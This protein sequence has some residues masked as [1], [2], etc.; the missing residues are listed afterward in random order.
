MTVDPNVRTATRTLLALCAF[1]ADSL[2]NRLAL[3]SHQ[4]MRRASLAPD[5]APALTLV[6][7]ARLSI[8]GAIVLVGFGLVLL[9]RSR[10]RP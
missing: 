2:L 8:R 5:S 9:G 10:A 3:G 1:A 7:I 4:S 6:I